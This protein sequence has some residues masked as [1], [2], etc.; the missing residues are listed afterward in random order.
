[1][2]CDK[3]TE[4]IG[5]LHRSLDLKVELGGTKSIP[6]HKLAIS[7]LNLA[8]AHLADEALQPALQLGR[9]AVE[10]GLR[11]YKD[12]T[13][14]ALPRFAAAT[15]L[16]RAGMIAEAVVI[17]EEVLRTKTS[18]FGNYRT[19]TRNALYAVAIA[20]NKLGKLNE[21]M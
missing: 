21:A 3:Y 10:L 18:L 16:F 4:A 14:V 8:V 6:D 9:E 15:C 2:D 17:F 19:P 12:G 20:Q 11:E 5:Y 13:T 7:K 1:M